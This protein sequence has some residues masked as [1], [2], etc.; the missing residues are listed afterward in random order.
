MIDKPVC[1]RDDFLEPP[2]FKTHRNRDES[3]RATIPLYWGRNPSLNLDDLS[4]NNISGEMNSS[5]TYVPYSHSNIIKDWVASENRISIHSYLLPWA[6]PRDPELR[7]RYS[8][9]FGNLWSV[10]SDG[11][12]KLNLMSDGFWYMMEEEDVMASLQ[13]SHQKLL[14]TRRRFQ[15]MDFD[16]SSRHTKYEFGGETDET[17]SLS[18][19]IGPVGPFLPRGDQDSS[20]MPA[21]SSLIRIANWRRLM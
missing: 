9:N 11:R 1:R 17:L 15:I 5:L 8:R 3:R 6:Y 12:L 18:L 13:S 19:D 4:T 10:P 20:Q 21:R 16:S 7:I 14:T 2:E